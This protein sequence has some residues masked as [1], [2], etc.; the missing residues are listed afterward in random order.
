[1]SLCSVAGKKKK[2]ENLFNPSGRFGSLSGGWA[3][4][5]VQNTAGQPT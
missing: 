3:G 4:G 1:M 5:A 2:F